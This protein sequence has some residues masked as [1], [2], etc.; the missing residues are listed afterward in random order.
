MDINVQT[1]DFGQDGIAWDLA[2]GQLSGRLQAEDGFDRHTAG[3]GRKGKQGQ[4]DGDRQ[5]ERVEHGR[6]ET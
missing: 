3:M 5:S 1:G 2:D 6:T 4:D